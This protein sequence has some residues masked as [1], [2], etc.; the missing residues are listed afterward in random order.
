MLL[1]FKAF[2]D[3]IV[4]DPESVAVE[5]TARDKAGLYSG[6]IFLGSVRYEALKQVY[7]NRVCI[8]LQKLKT[9]FLKI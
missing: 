8:Y 6:V 2:Q 3:L 1:F 5:L 4:R 9:F 7:D